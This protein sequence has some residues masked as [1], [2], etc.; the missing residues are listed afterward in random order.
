MGTLQLKLSA[1]SVADHHSICRTESLKA[2]DAPD[3][4]PDAQVSDL[5]ASPRTA[6]SC[7]RID[8]QMVRLV[9]CSAVC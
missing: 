1:R 3:M 2:L 5:P 6:G 9:R 8:E 4:G 7:R